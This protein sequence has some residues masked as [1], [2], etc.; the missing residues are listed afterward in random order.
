MA[1]KNMK[2]AYVKRVLKVL[3]YIEDH[4]EEEIHT[5]T[6][7]DIACYAPFHFH[8]IFQ[9]IV[10]ETT[11]QYIK[12]LRLEKAAAKL[13]YSQESITDIA[14]IDFDSSSAFAKAFKKC[15]GTSPRNYRLLY[16]EANIMTRKIQ[17]LLPIIPA[18][19]PIQDIGVWFVRR[20]GNYTISSQQAWDTMV[21]FIKKNKLDMQN[22]RCFSIVPDNPEITSEE[23]LRFDACIEARADIRPEGEM[24]HQTLKGGKYA[25]FTHMGSHEQISDTFDRI[26]LKWLPDADQNIDDTRLIFCEHFN[27]EYS[28]EDAHKRLTKIYLPVA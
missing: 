1:I 23:K 2:P 10:G 6:L 8:R 3:I 24:A 13:R 12:R 18:I 16:T 5:K 21:D 14:L 4:L 17:D 28:D 7:A 20:T 11:Q 22:L 19:E 26:F 25:V 27:L 15:M 9:S